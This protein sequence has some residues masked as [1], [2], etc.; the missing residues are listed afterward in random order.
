MQ[1][2]LCSSST[3]IVVLL[4]TGCAASVPPKAAESDASQKW[5]ADVDYYALLKLVDTRIHPR[6]NRNVSKQDVLEVLGPGIDDPNEYPN[7][8]PDHWVYPS[9]RPIPIGSYLYICFDHED[10]V[11]EVSWGSE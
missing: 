3:A 1:Q 4:V 5:H 7:A 8:G 10:M 6:W 2:R 11:K 9:R